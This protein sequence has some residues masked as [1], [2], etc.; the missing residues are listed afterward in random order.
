MTV[1]A[2]ETIATGWRAGAGG[3]VVT[4]PAGEGP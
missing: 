4:A 1:P 3:T 2:E